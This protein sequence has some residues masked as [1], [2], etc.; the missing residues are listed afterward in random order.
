MKPRKNSIK[1]FGAGNVNR[2]KKKPTYFS[3]SPKT[4]GGRQELPASL[5][6]KAVRSTKVKLLEWADKSGALMQ[7]RKLVKNTEFL[8]DPWQKDAV[9]ALS[10][11]HNVVVDAPTTSGKT[12]VVEAYFREH[13]ADPNFRACYTCPVKSLA[14]DKV[15]EF[16]Q[17][18]RIIWNM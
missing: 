18:D 7:Q 17:V 9:S 1:K 5:V 11:G 13:L 6:F 12:R 2:S 4:E 15:G 14:A 10:R 8:L 3:R 16:E